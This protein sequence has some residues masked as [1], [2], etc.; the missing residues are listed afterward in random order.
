MSISSHS[1]DNTRVPVERRQSAE[2]KMVGEGAAIERLRKQVE[3][4]GPHFRTMLLRGESGTGK[5][6][7]AR[8]LHASSRGKDEAFVVCRSA[9]LDHGV[10]RQLG[11]LMRRAG[12]GTLFF[13]AIEEMSLD[14]QDR[15]L[16]A[17][18]QK[19]HTRIIASCSE[20][21][22]IL[23]VSGD[24]R[25][26][27]YHR[28]GMVEIVLEPLRNRTEDI[29]A[30]A[31]HFLK[32]A[33]LAHEKSVTMIAQDAMDYLTKHPWPGNVQEMEDSIRSGVQACAGNVLRARDLVSMIERNNVTVIRG[34]SESMRLQDVIERHVLHV[35]KGCAG[36]KLRTAEQLGISR[37]TLYRMLDGGGIGAE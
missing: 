4:F 6:L 35:L 20:D 17:M 28:L 27:L 25:R 12:R 31:L 11:V 37:S 10:D 34:A 22:R 9:T 33:S 13:D 5:E 7:T 23:T 30:L 32:Q 18:K 29:P 21:L 8:A 14:A 26:E 36:N 3:R 15:L 19:M 24:F 16:W 1:V 2:L